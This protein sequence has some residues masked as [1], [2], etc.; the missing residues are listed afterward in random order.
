MAYWPMEATR[1]PSR[2][3]KLPQVQIDENKERDGERRETD[4]GED[5]RKTGG[6]YRRAT[7]ALGQPDFLLWPPLEEEK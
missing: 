4:G 2:P 1:G 5:G 6:A 3:L 7:E